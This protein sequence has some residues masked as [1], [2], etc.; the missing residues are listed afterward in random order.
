MTKLV[1]PGPFWAIHTPV[2]PENIDKNIE[3]GASLKINNEKE[4]I[5]KK[6]PDSTEIM[7]KK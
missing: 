4:T 6:T 2:L 1:M 5:L 7:K 3:K